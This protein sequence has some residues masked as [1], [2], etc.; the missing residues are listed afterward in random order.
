MQNFKK[1]L[2]TSKI[3]WIKEID[4]LSLSPLPK[5]PKSLQFLR[6][7]PQNKNKIIT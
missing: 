4:K 6:Q 7:I 1:E 3:D 5:I 2:Y